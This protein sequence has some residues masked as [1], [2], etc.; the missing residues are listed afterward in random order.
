MEEFEAVGGLADALDYP[1][2]VGPEAQGEGSLSQQDQQKRTREAPDRPDDHGEDGQHSEGG[3]RQARGTGDQDRRALAPRGQGLGADAG[4][5]ILADQGEFLAEVEH[6]AELG[7]GLLASA[8]LV[9]GSGLEEPAGQGTLA[10]PGA[11]GRQQFE[12]GA[13]AEQVEVVA[14]RVLGVGEALASHALA[15]PAVLDARQA[16]LIEGGSALGAALFAEHMLVQKHQGD[17]GGRWQQ[18]P[19]RRESAAADG[20]PN[21]NDSGSRHGKLEVAQV[22]VHPIEASRAGETFGE[23]SAV[24]ARRVGRCRRRGGSI[25]DRHTGP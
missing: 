9:G 5:K 25:V 1:L 12:Q 19:P 22:E 6:G 24:F 16:A 15:R 13:A 14:V 2:H 20:E 4:A 23:A 21:Q 7:D 11:A 18:E 3:G 10:G 17:Q 8:D